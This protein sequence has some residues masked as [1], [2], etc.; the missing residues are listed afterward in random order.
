MRKIIHYVVFITLVFFLAIQV[1]AAE[2]AYKRLG[3]RFWL[4]DNWKTSGNED[5]AVFTANSPD[6]EVAL[7]F[8]TSKNINEVENASDELK[9][10]SPLETKVNNVDALLFKGTAQSKEEGSAVVLR[11]GIYHKDGKILLVYATVC[12]DELAKYDNVMEKILK[13]VKMAK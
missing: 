4:P 1:Y 3:F 10:G 11:V 8:W 2:Y 9:V 13:S 12:F 6:E 5:A 7:R